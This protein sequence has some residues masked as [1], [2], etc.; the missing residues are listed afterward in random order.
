MP[1]RRKRRIPTEEENQLRL[2]VDKAV[3]AYQAGAP[4][5]G[6][7][8]LEL[9]DG[10]LGRFRK[11]LN[12]GVW[13]PTDVVSKAFIRLFISSADMEMAW[14]NS[15]QVEEGD[16]PGFRMAAENAL[17]KLRR[18]LY[19]YD[20]EDINHELALALLEMAKRYTSN[21]GNPRFHNFVAKAYHFYAAQHINKMT[22]N[23]LS[24]SGDPCDYLDDE[25]AESLSRE[26]TLL[27][28]PEHQ[29]LT[30]AWV[31]GETCS[32]IFRELS[33]ID[34]KIL[35]LAYEEKWRDYQI[36]ELLGFKR[37]EVTRRRKEA[38]QTLR[39]LIGERA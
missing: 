1:R 27:P 12:Q 26:E 7:R 31:R 11:M 36:A 13:D 24:L 23:S 37:E 30:E 20:E 35:A 5:A 4:E 32:E 25:D 29:E 9:F 19:L 39:R 17:A 8:L 15:E 16:A 33:S 2:E 34:R 10:F 21:D 38:I 28:G 3:K 22:G 14:T 18:H 6:A